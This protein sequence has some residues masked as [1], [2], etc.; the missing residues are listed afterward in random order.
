MFPFLGHTVV[1]S[2]RALLMHPMPKYN[3]ISFLRYQRVVN[4]FLS[5]AAASNIGVVAMPFVTSQRVDSLKLRNRSTTRKVKEGRD[6]LITGE[7]RVPPK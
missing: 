5:T 6:F 2:Q 4:V 3:K 1:T 7:Q